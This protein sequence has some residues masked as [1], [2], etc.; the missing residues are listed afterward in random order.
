MCSAGKDPNYQA[1]P[2][3]SVSRTYVIEL[4]KRV[5]HVLW[6]H[7]HITLHMSTISNSKVI[8]VEELILMY[9]HL[10]YK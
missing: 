2:L 3:S 1:W 9:A 7:P 5:W 8:D 10:A 4:E 6:I